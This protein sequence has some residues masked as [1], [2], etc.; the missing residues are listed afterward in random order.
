[1]P[2][3]SEESDSKKTD[4]FAFV[5]PG[6]VRKEISEAMAEDPLVD[7]H[8]DT[9][10][11]RS[12]GYLFLN[13]FEPNAKEV[14]ERAFAEFRRAR[15]EELVVDLRYNSGGAITV[16]NQL[17]S[18]IAGNPH[19]GEVLYRISHNPKYSDA[20]EVGRFKHHPNGLDLARVFVLTS[21]HSCSASE[22]LVVSLRAY[23]PVIMIGE[24][25]CGKPF[26]SVGVRFGNQI[27]RVLSFR[28]SDAKGQG[29]YSE[30]LVP[31][32]FK[33][34]DLKESFKL[35]TKNDPMFTMAQRFVASGRCD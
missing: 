30:G 15:V 10:S 34:D 5:T 28:A 33:R 4:V 21:E 7:F 27:F 25:T 11:G 1:L 2:R 26:G 23:L 32:C 6:N 29:F 9:E 31:H 16:V 24:V 8:V 12:I 3:D 20:D 13:G 19:A 14:L 17:A 35:G 18:L 22:L